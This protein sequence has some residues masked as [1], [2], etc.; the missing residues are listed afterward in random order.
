VVFIVVYTEADV[1]STSYY[2]NNSMHERGWEDGP[3]DGTMSAGEPCRVDIQKG[4][5]KRALDWQVGPCSAGD[6]SLL[7]EADPIFRHTAF[8]PVE[9]TMLP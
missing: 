8:T 1:N 9:L 4:G 6:T 7:A 3:P 2:R 5:E